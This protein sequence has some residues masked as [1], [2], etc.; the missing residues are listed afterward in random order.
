MKFS[1][2]TEIQCPRGSLSKERLE[3]FLEQ[4]AFADQLGFRTLWIAELH[5]QPEFSV[6]SAPYPVLGAVSQRTRRIRLGVAVNTLPLHHPLQVAEQA[7]M[8]DLLS[9]GRMDFAVGAGHPHSRAYE[10]FGIDHRKTRALMEES[11]WIIQAAWTREALS[12][13]GEFFRIPGVVVNPKPLQQP[14]PP[15]RV[16]ASSMDGV[17]FTA[18]LGLD[19]FL[20]IHTRTREQVTAL[21]TAYWEG[22]RRHGHATAKRELGLLVPLHVA[23][24][25][26]EAR[27][28]SERGVM[29]YYRIIREMRASYI[30]WLAHRGEDLP[31][32]LGK[33]SAAEGLTF[34]RVCAEHAA[35][36]DAAAVREKLGALAE[37]TGAREILAWINIGGMPHEAVVDSMRR[38]AEEIMPRRGLEG[39]EPAR[40][41]SQIGRGSR[42]GLQSKDKEG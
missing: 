28:R 13:E 41:R 14:P 36:G 19:L 37:A 20:P 9:G 35:I 38:V 29:E 7:A 22:L 8:L 40:K 33:T 16:A 1:L 3:E 26:E 34:E 32:R 6:L 17:E 27:R 2:F 30:E 24:T 15:I 12:Y 11:L 31:E 21:A 42:R 5:F 23:S 4:A 10:G 25:A 18:R 39:N